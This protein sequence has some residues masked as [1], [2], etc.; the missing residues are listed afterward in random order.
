MKF[1]IHGELP[2]LN[3]IIAKAKSHYHA[4]RKLKKDAT[5]LVKYS[6]QKLP[7]LNGKV[8][9]D[10]T[11]YCKN[12]A[13]DKDNI[14]VAKKFIFDGLVA[15]KKLKNDGWREIGNWQES[16]VVDKKNPRIEVEIKGAGK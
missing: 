15:A 7:I 9:L 12:R 11:Y 1:V 3:E 4:Y 13:K 5:A 8:D 14:A 10:I 16:F 2:T 6:C